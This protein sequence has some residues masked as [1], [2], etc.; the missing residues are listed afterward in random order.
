[1]APALIILGA[2]ICSITAKPSLARG[3]RLGGLSTGLR[4]PRGAVCL[5][6]HASGHAGLLWTMLVCPSRIRL[7]LALGTRPVQVSLWWRLMM[8]KTPRR[9]RLA[10]RGSPPTTGRL[11]L[12]R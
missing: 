11:F 7:L 4:G 6:A 1:M 3:W 9:R 8:Q 5:V 10:V 12:L 2:Y